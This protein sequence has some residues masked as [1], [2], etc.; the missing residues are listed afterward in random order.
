MSALVT[1]IVPGR[2]VAAFAPQAI[3]SLQAQ[4]EPR[5]R[6]VLIDDGSVDGTGDLFVRAAAEDGRFEVLRH[7]RSIGLGAARNV[8]LDRVGTEFLGFL[9][10]DDELAPTALERLLSI[11]RE[12]GSDFAAGAY[13]RLRLGAGGYVRGRV[14]PWVSAATSPERRRATIAEHP[15]ASGNIVAWSKICRTGFWEREGFRFPEGVA[16]EDQVLAQRMYTRAAA[17]DTIPDA[18]VGWRVRADGGSITQSKAQR[19]VMH[20][21][22][23]ALRGG[24]EVLREAR[25][26][27]AVRSRVRLILSMDLPS[28][29]EIARTHPDPGYAADLGEFTAELRALPEAAGVEADP[30]FFPALA[31]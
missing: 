25:A 23:R 27:A 3:A 29:A 15:D 17:F 20:D 16:Y 31:W 26:T 10:A 14:Q 12:T 1:M 7:P 30:S 21:Y 8:G 9:D 19:V 4:T 22:L 28:L 6:A 24:I 5:W 13:G 2:D 11:L 18:V